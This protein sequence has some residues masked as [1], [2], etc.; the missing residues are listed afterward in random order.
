L[1][2]G[3]D[4]TCLVALNKVKPSSFSD[5][6]AADPQLDQSHPV[7][8]APQHWTLPLP[9]TLLLT[10]PDPA[11]EAYYAPPVQPTSPTSP[12]LPPLPHEVVPPSVHTARPPS[13]TT[14]REAAVALITC[15]LVVIIGSLSNPIFV[16]VD[17]GLSPP[18]PFNLLCRQVPVTMPHDEKLLAMQ[19]EALKAGIPGFGEVLN[20][21]VPSFGEVLTA[22]VFE[23]HIKE[24]RKEI[25]IVAR[26]SRKSILFHIRY[27]QANQRAL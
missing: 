12:Y 1:L 18:Q 15:V 25:R 17:P 4:S 8:Q 21:G 9:E 27:F 13:Q 10:A 22:A 11:F 23:R 19:N 24:E 7:T 6:L 26:L 5:R 2:G 16:T 3:E 14:R 20:A